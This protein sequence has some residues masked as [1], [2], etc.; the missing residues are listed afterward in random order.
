MGSR[1]ERPRQG[2]EECRTF[3][4]RQPSYDVTDAPLELIDSKDSR[5]THSDKRSN[6]S[7]QLCTDVT[8]PHNQCDVSDLGGRLESWMVPFTLWTTSGTL[9][10]TKC[11]S[12]LQL[13]FILSSLNLI[14]VFIPNN[15][16]SWF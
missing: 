14:I 12:G 9:F 7:T 13:I 15:H 2:R 1:A 16:F 6:A 10:K 8:F 11:R 5:M 4:Q 3:N